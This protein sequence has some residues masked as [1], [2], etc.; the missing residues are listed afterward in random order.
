M[1]RLTTLAGAAALLGSA[2][3]TLAQQPSGG[4]PVEANFPN[5]PGKQ[6]VVEVCGGC[7]DIVR[8]TAGYTPKAG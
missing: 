8:L 2:T 4:P 3:G 1:R 5:G 7:H 6:T